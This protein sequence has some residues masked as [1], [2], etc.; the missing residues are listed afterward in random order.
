MALDVCVRNILCALSAPVLGALSGIIQTQRAA[1]T[2]QI[3]GLQTQI[4]R[5]D[6]AAAPLEAGRV[7]LNQSLGQLRAAAS[8]VP[9][10]LIEGCGDLGQLN[11][12]LVASIDQKTAELNETVDEL[13]RVVSFRDELQTVVDEYTAIIEQ[14]DEILLTIQECG[15]T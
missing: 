10:S 14:F 11:I 2:A 15:Q 1:L 9:L 6:V 8:L 5:L 12:N 3:T 4:L 7:I 13:T